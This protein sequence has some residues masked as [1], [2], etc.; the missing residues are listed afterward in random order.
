MN[1]NK[2]SNEETIQKLLGRYAGTKGGIFANKTRKRIVGI[3]EL[4][5]RYPTK[6]RFLDE[7]TEY[8]KPTLFD[9][10]L[11][12]KYADKEYVNQ[13]MTWE[14]LKPVVEA[15]LSKPIDDRAE[16]DLTRAEIAQLFIRAGFDYL[17][18][19]SLPFPL[20]KILNDA[21]D[22]IDYLVRNFPHEP[23]PLERYFRYPG[24]Y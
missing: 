24:A 19:I 14:A 9:L 6:K 22:I 15:L 12:I 13:V 5:K 7:M 3:E 23:K 4:S 10:E 11:F 17:Q 8:I 21:S 2:N 1:A 18:S 16:A 20:D